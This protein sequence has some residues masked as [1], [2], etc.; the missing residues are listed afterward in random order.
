MR[1]ILGVV[2]LG[3]V[4]CGKPTL[5][6]AAESVRFTTTETQVAGCTSKGL[7]RAKDGRGGLVAKGI[8]WR[9]V[10]RKLREE[11]SLLRA[12]VVLLKVQRNGFWGS[13][14]AGEAFSCP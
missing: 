14:G 5:T 9:A 13:E 11:S 7:V 10:E 4:G 8:A 12:N 1:W 3:V 2:V 6:P